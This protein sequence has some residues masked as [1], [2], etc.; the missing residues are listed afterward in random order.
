MEEKLISMDD[1]IQYL[2]ETFS[3]HVNRGGYVSVETYFDSVDE[4]IDD[5]RDEFEGKIRGIQ[6]DLETVGLTLFN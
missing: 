4:L 1:V 3:E 5:F 2:R 6:M